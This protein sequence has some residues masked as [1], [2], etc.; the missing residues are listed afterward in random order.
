MS[1]NSLV[2]SIILLY[3]VCISNKDGILRSIYISY[4]MTIREAQRSL[5]ELRTYMVDKS[6]N[7]SAGCQV[8]ELKLVEDFN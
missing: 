4:D 2:K 5:V 8:S 6:S 7:N 1:Q 3:T